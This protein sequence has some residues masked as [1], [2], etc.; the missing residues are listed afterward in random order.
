MTRLVQRSLRY[1]HMGYGSTFERDLLLD[2][3]R[4]V[5][6]TS[7]VRRN[8]IAEFEN[9]PESYAVGG[10]TIFPRPCRGDGEPT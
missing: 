1:V 4:G 2:V 5:V 10:M 8:G 7:R 6:V 9:A 3:E